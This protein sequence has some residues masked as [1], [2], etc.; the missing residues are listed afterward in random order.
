MYIY[1]IISYDIISYYV[2][3]YYNINI[4]NYKYIDCL[5]VNEREPCCRIGEYC[6]AYPESSNISSAAKLCG[7]CQC[8]QRIQSNLS[9]RSLNQYSTMW[10]KW[11]LLPATMTSSMRNN[12][13]KSPDSSH[14]SM[15][16]YIFLGLGCHQKNSQVGNLSINHPGIEYH[17]SIILWYCVMFCASGGKQE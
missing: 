7:Q 12:L 4:I 9:P 1:I 2:I 14:S 17:G 5:A 13:H 10:M 3:L 6:H 11:N 8:I 16:F 15:F